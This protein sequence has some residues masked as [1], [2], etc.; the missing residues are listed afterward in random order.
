MDLGK[1]EPAGPQAKEIASLRAPGVGKS[2]VHPRYIGRSAY[3]NPGNKRG[4]EA[5]D[6]AAEVSRA[7][8]AGL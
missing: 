7:N 2:L 3:W 6:E 5:G 1:V 4:K 8:S